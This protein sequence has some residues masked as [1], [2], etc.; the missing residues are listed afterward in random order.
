[1]RQQEE[2]V[3]I[4]ANPSPDAMPMSMST[5][6]S[7]STF[8][9]EPVLGASP[10]LPA[11]RLRWWHEVLFILGFYLC[12]SGIRN[13]FGSAT[14]SPA[15]ALANAQDVIDFEKALGLFHEQA[16]QGWFL[17]YEAFLRFW[18]IYYGTLH[19]IVTAGAMLWLYRRY[20]LRYKLWRNTLALTTGLALVGFSL[21]PLM[22]P[23]LVSDCSTVFSGCAGYDFVDTLAKV[24]GLWSF[25]SGAMVSV[26]NQYAAMPSLH[27]AWSSWCCLA[28]LPTVRRRWVKALLLIYPW[29]TLFAIIVTAN[30]YWL[31]AAGG[32]LGLAAGFGAAWLIT[33]WSERRR[34]QRFLDEHRA[35]TTVAGA[36]NATAKV[37]P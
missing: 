31:D 2:E 5:S 3:L 14:V 24:G 10:T 27:F 26:S 21:F 6:T 11:P 15:K 8:A 19:F 4:D 20:P 9:D 1:V 34:L 37:A 30:H 33:R 32:A 13:L 17:G 18:N 16:I 25:E 36:T 29:T 28:L 23:R 7:T 35:T 12:Y 22:P